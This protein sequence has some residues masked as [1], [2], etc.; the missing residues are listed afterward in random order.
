L[1][2]ER[3]G[4]VSGHPAGLNFGDCTSYAV[5]S[6]S[7]RALAFKGDDFVHSDLELLKLG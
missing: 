7:G 2:F 5:A 6:S 1:A 3:F 4:T